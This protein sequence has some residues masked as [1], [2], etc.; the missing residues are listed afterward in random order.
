MPEPRSLEDLDVPE[1][2]LLAYTD[3]LEQWHARTGAF[4]KFALDR[5]AAKAAP[6]KKA[7]E[8]P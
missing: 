6:A 5:P 1:R 4:A 7:K 2:D 8:A 3:V